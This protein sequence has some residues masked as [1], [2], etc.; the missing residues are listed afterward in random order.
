MWERND[1]IGK[2]NI[3][4]NQ[5]TAYL[6]VAVRNRRIQ[7]RRAI[8]KRQQFEETLDPQEHQDISVHEPDWL[9]SF[10]ILEQIEDAALQQALSH[11]TRKELY[12]L[13]ARVLEGKSIGDIAGELGM[14]YKSVAS[15]YYRLIKK[16]KN[17]MEG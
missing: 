6:V 14:N 16:L 9:A 11:V 2:D 13:F 5:F 10:P 7:F 15:I 17:E 1:G 8:H 4:Q 3:L 12:I